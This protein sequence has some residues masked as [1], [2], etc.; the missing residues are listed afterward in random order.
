M[1]YFNEHDAFAAAWLHNL[2]PE[3]VVDERD[4]RDVQPADVVGYERCHFFGGIGGWQLALELAG[5]GG[6]CWTG[7]CPCQPF[8]AAGRKKAMSDERHLWPEFY[9]LIREC[10]PSVIFGEQVERAVVNGW[11]DLV[12]DDLE[13]EGYACGAHVLP[14]CSVGARHIRQRIWWVANLVGQ[15]CEKRKGKP[16]NAEFSWEQ[17]TAYDTFQGGWKNRWKAEPGMGR[18]VHG[19]RPSN[20]EVRAFGNAIVPQLAATFIRAFMECET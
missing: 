13:A 4:I 11:L 10:R 19:V 16:K 5:W 1:T 15:R 20:P 2:Y 17:S 3:A 14:A 18:V 12:F 9:R 6:A 8:S 7:S